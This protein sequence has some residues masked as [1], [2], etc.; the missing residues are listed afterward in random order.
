MKAKVNKVTIRLVQG[1]LLSLTVEVLVHS[2]TP[3]LSLPDWLTRAAGSALE[4]ETLLIG[5]CDVGS[6][7]MTGAGRLSAKKMI[8]AVGPRWG[9][10]SERGKLAN[11][12]WETL[13]LAEEHEHKSIALPPI[14][15]GAVG[16]YPVENCA[17]VMMQ[18][19]VDFTFEPLRFLREIIVCV[20]NETE[21]QAFQREF[22]RQIED[23]K[24]TGSGGKVPAL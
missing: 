23:L 16:G 8:H 5:W 7:V 13:R 4:R 20:E 1:D 6:A 12:T 17:R 10:G 19:I 18:Q 2:T 3:T 21:F 9:E 22:T 14:A 11:T 15:T 24:D